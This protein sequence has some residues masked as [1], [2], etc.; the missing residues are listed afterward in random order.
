MNVTRT[1]LKTLLA[2]PGRTYQSTE[3][4]RAAGCT[5]R[6]QIAATPASLAN[7]RD[8]KAITRIGE[9]RQTRWMVENTPA[10]IERATAYLN[11]PERGNGRT[12]GNPFNRGTPPDETPREHAYPP[13][14]AVGLAPYPPEPL[15]YQVDDDG[16]LQISGRNT[17][18]TYLLIP[19]L[20]AVDLLE[21]ARRSA[22]HLEAA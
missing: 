22:P 21:F 12:P 1:L 7:L 3:L 4:A 11:K 18:T 9:R 16:D 8:A 13:V 5:L 19:K 15:R 2:E 10:A 6:N 14:A 17:G 20:D